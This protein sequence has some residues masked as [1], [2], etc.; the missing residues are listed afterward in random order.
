MELGLDGS[1]PDLHLET[2]EPAKKAEIRLSQH[3]H[4]KGFAFFFGQIL[5][6]H[7]SEYVWT[8]PAEEGRFIDGEEFVNSDGKCLENI[9]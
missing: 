4:L 9:D 2:V 3:L 6:D 5:T 8:S 1:L 7:I